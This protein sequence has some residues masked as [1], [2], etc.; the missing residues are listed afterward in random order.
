VTKRKGGGLI[1]DG[2]LAYQH[3]IH[4]KIDVLVPI[5]LRGVAEEDTLI[6]MGVS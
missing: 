5:M 4:Q 2:V 1:E 3:A 6:G